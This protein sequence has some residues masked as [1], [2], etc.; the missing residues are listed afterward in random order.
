[1]II[2]ETFSVSVGFVNYDFGKPALDITVHLLYV[3]EQQRSH[4][5]KLGRIHSNISL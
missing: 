2:W 5:K 3:S 4:Q 1:M